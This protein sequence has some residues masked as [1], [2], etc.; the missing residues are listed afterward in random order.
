MGG[1]DIIPRVDEQACRKSNYIKI[2]VSRLRICFSNT[3][4]LITD[5]YQ[6]HI[7]AINILKEPV[8]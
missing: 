1:K 3:I 5:L 2:V 7:E 8:L 6:F 4:N